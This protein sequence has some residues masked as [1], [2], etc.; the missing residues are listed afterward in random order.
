MYRHTYM[1]VDSTHSFLLFFFHLSKYNPYISHSTNSDF[2]DMQLYF[3]NITTYVLFRT[4]I[5][6]SCRNKIL[7]AVHYFPWSGISGTQ[8][9][10]SLRCGEGVGT[11]LFHSLGTTMQSAIWDM[12]SPQVT[13]KTSLIAVCQAP[14][15]LALCISWGQRKH[16]PAHWCWLRQFSSS[17]LP[18]NS[19][20][21]IPLIPGPCW[22]LVE[23]CL[24]SIY[25]DLSY[26]C[27][28][29]CSLGHSRWCDRMWWWDGEV[30]TSMFSRAHLGTETQV[31][32][33]LG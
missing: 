22:E 26:S 23:V 18:M 20:K 30:K 32:S 15:S 5:L 10:F 7:G 4:S 2:H 3:V 9:V 21:I 29:Y 8:E 19:Q 17:V 24:C 27:S 16:F 33:L 11:E 28:L 13:T 31:L 14:L 25:P 6:L 1:G 12:S